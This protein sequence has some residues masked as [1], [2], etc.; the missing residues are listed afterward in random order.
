LKESE[1]E[2]IMVEGRVNADAFLHRHQDKQKN[3]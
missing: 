3:N 1:E 2:R